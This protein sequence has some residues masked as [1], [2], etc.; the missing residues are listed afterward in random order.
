MWFSRTLPVTSARSSGPWSRAVKRSRLRATPSASGAQRSPRT[1]L[2]TS[3]W[4]ERMRGRTLVRARTFSVIKVIEIN[5]FFCFSFIVDIMFHS[6]CLQ[7]YIIFFCFDLTTDGSLMQVL[8]VISLLQSFT[9][10]Y[11]L[12]T[13]WTYCNMLQSDTLSPL[14]MRTRC[15]DNVLHSSAADSCRLQPKV[16]YKYLNI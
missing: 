14:M 6:Y 16:I 9:L 3:L 10:V 7:N 5:S 4:R 1:T 11:L 8:L 12:K 15:L 2:Q 13:C